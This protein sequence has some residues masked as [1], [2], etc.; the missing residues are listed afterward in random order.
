MI[1]ASESRR[2]NTAFDMIVFSFLDRFDDVFSA[3]IYRANLSFGAIF[4]PSCNANLKCDEAGI[5]TKKL[6]RG[7]D[8]FGRDRRKV[9]KTFDE[10]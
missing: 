8:A 1:A 10:G 7:W 3:V 4:P 6:L 9:K 5:S 2:P